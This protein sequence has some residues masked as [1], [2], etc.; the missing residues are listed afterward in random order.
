MK[1]FLALLA[2]LYLLAPQPLP[3][4]PD[5]GAG[6]VLPAGLNPE[7]RRWYAVFQEGNAFSEGWVRISRGLLDRLPPELHAEFR[8][9]LQRLGDRLGRE[10]CRDNRIRRIDTGMLKRWG[11]ELKQAG[12]AAALRA[13]IARINARIDARLRVPGQGR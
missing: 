5:V 13:A 7:E 11:R 1:A 4:A 9:L 6:Y 12:D 10:W 2:G 3:A 8:P